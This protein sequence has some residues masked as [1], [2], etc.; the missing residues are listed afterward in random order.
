MGSHVLLK[1]AWDGGN[2][3][4]TM[5]EECVVETLIWESSPA[6]TSAKWIYFKAVTKTVAAFGVV[7]RTSLPTEMAVMLVEEIWGRMLRET[8]LEAVVLDWAIA[9]SC[10]LG[11]VTVTWI[12]ESAR[13]MSMA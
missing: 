6:D 5:L 2:A 12:P 7:V 9:R 13:A 10:W 8:Q 1:K 3:S 4:R 11:M